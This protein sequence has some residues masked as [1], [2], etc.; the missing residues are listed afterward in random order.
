MAAPPP[1]RLLTSI[2]RPL[3]RLDDHRRSVSQHFGDAVHYLVGVVAGADD[4]VRPDLGSVLDHDFKSLAAR[5]LAKLREKSDV[6]ADQGLQGSADRTED[7]ARTHRDAAHNA[8]VAHDA[9]ARQFERGRDHVMRDRITRRRDG[10]GSLYV[11]LVFH[12]S[13][14]GGRLSREPSVRLPRRMQSDD[15]RASLFLNRKKRRVLHTVAL[16]SLQSP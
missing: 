5:L 13:I 8:E 11:N 6:S 1:K 2:A 12:S 16:I 4:G 7:R 14:S 10:I 3:E 15:L 9:E